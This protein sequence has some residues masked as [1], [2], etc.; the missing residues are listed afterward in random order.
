MGERPFLDQAGH[1]RIAQQAVAQNPDLVQQAREKR[2]FLPL[3]RAAQRLTDASG[4]LKI[5][6]A[7][8]G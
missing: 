6:E 3:I 2:N 7:D 5:E 1:E 4:A 8:R